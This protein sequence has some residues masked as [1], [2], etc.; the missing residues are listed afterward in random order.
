MRTVVFTR[1]CFHPSVSRLARRL[2]VV[3]ATTI[4]LGSMLGAGVFVAFAPAAAAAGSGLLVSLVLAGFVAYCNARSSAR[5]AAMYPESGGTYVYGRERL[6]EWWGFTAGWGFVVGKIASCAAMG[7]TVGAYLAPGYEKAV[8]IAA[9][10]VL[11]TVTYLGVTRTAAVTKVLLVV[12]LV[13][14]VWFVV[15]GLPKA[16]WQPSTWDTAGVLRA[17]GLLF[18]AFAGYARIATLGEEVKDPRRTI[19]RAITTALAVALVIYLVVGATVLGVLGPERLAAA[20]APLAEVLPA[21]TIGAGA[22][23]L[24]ALLALIAG[25]SRTTLAMARRRDLPGPLADVHRAEIAVAVVVCGLVLVF[26]VRGAIGFSSFGVLVYYAIANMS[27]FTLDGPKWIPVAGLVG[28]V[29]LAGS[30]PLSSVLVGLAVFAVGL[31]GRWVLR[32][33]G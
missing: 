7:M 33:S 14:L 3:D 12:V 15:V 31:G 27:A 19:P 26:D 25:V 18:F 5:L 24:G 23:A 6:G 9:V 13:V 4:G 20:T 22:G 2:G 21:T 1:S 8:A 10:A 29:V 17:A 30:L 16:H 32:R 11:T 28:C